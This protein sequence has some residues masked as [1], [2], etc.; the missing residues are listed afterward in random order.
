MNP[1]SRDGTLPGLPPES[2]AVKL[3]RSNEAQ[4]PTAETVER[5]H[6]VVVEVI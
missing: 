4:L 2:D 1:Q 3:S 6:T 5:S